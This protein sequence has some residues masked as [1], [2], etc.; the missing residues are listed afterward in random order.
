MAIT[1]SSSDSATYVGSIDD[2]IPEDSGSDGKRHKAGAEIRQVK[3]ALLT[4]FPSVTGAV[5]ATHTELNLLDGVT[6]STAELNILDGVT[7]TA[8][9]INQLD[10]HV[11]L[12]TDYTAKTA[13]FN[14]AS[15]NRY[16]L[17]SSGGAFTASLPAGSAGLKIG[18]VD[19]GSAETHNITVAADGTEK[20][21]AST[22]DLLI[23]QNNAAIV[24]EYVDATNGWV[25]I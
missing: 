15:G 22:D 19:L 23:D 16:L 20:I 3:T 4:T 6:A 10:D 14:A 5:T 7:A 21:L 12:A 24:L 2:T 8:T 11:L 13:N 17:D 1:Y 18:L 25:L 9:E